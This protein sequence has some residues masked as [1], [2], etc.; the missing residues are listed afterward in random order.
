MQNKETVE[1]ALKR[2]YPLNDELGWE[3]IFMNRER[4]VDFKNGIAWQKQ[5]E[6]DNAIALLA[7]YNSKG[8]SYRENTLIQDAAMDFLSQLNT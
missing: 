7:W 1:E 2:L 8:D 4:R 3:V 5:S 6:E